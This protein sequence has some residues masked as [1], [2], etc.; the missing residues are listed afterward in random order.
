MV[1]AV[2][3]AAI[4]DLSNSFAGIQGILDLS[5]PAQ[6]LSKIQRQR[7]D[8]LLADG[9]LL[10]QRTRH[11]ALGTRP[12]ANPESGTAWREAFQTETRAMA[13]AFRCDIG[14]RHQGDPADDQ[15]PGELARG[16]ALAVTRQVLPFFRPTQDFPGLQIE[17]EADARQWRLAWQ[18]VHDLPLCLKAGSDP[19]R[20]ISAYWAM[21]I[22]R[23]LRVEVTFDQGRILAR[24]PRP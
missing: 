14:I 20:D 2:V 6:P 5:D 23:A 1:Q 10:L 15:W 22:S 8:S 24:L 4:H 18:P 17:T 19:P 16:W 9:F 3:G 11:L 12:E 21:E 7:L 13:A